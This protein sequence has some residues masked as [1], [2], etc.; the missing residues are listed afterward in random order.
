MLGRLFLQKLTWTEQQ[1]LYFENSSKIE[2]EKEKQCIDLVFL[3]EKR[4][5]FI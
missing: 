5:A 1:I 4:D 2:T 3:F